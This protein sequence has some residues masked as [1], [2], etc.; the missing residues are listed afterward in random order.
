MRR[1]FLASDTFDIL[2]FF[3]IKISGENKI[4]FKVRKPSLVNI[5]YHFIYPETL[6]N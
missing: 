6:I 5:E 3:F 4:I 2:C 1:F